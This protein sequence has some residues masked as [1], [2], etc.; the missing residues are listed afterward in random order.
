MKLLIIDFFRITKYLTAIRKILDRIIDL[1]V[2]R[3]SYVSIVS[4]E[5]CICVVFHVILYSAWVIHFDL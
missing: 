2:E 3:V 5:V 1:S 4:M